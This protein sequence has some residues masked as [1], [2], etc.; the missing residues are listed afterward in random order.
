MCLYIHIRNIQSS[1]P[2]VIPLLYSNSF[3]IHPIKSSIPFIRKSQQNIPCS[4]KWDESGLNFHSVLM[5]E[6]LNLNF[7]VLCH[8]TSLIFT[9]VI[10]LWGSKFPTNLM[11]IEKQLIKQEPSNIF[12]SGLSDPCSVDS[13]V[14]IVV[15]MQITRGLA[16]LMSEV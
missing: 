10:Y 9:Q 14:E 15:S 11:M 13:I 2:S 1:S 7:K 4:F 3:L 12:F 6:M 8:L 16:I 5:R